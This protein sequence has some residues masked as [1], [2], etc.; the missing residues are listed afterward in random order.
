MKEVTSHFV[1]HPVLSSQ[2]SHSASEFDQYVKPDA[3]KAPRDEHERLSK[4]PATG[5]H[6]H[7]HTHTLFLSYVS[8]SHKISFF[9]VGHKKKKKKKVQITKTNNA[10]TPGSPHLPPCSQS[11]VHFNNGEEETAGARL[12]V[13]PPPPCVFEGA[14]QSVYLTKF[15]KVPLLKRRRKK[16]HV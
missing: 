7:T 12:S 8:V 6:T 2:L 15:A 14:N 9:C 4:H 13:A 1:P 10:H 3:D 11:P 5:R 16:G